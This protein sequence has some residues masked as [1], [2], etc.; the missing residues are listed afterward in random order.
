MYNKYRT[1]I[2]VACAQYLSSAPVPITE[3]AFNL[4]QRKTWEIV[5]PSHHT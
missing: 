4:Q 5:Q 1:H 3:N 2:N